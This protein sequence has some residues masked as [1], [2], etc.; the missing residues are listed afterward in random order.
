MNFLKLIRSQSKPETF[1]NIPNEVSK[2]QQNIPPMPNIRSS[3]PNPKLFV[4]LDD[5][6]IQKKENE[7]RK[8]TKS[9]IRT[10]EILEKLKNNQKNVKE[11]GEKINNLLDNTKKMADLSENYLNQA[12]EIRKKCLK[13]EIKERKN[14]NDDNHINRSKKPFKTYLSTDK[15]VIG[16][17]KSSAIHE[18]FDHYVQDFIIPGESQNSQFQNLE[19]KKISS[20]NYKEKRDKNKKL[21]FFCC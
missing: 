21:L 2:T 6:L 15:S 16:T 4:I 7:K 13:S 10:N 12:K 1:E 17:G 5:D 8:I 18:N 19:P 3:N 11:R 9:V 14:E 20:N